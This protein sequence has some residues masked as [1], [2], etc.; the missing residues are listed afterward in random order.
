MQRGPRKMFD[1]RHLG[2]TCADCG[3]P[4]EELPF[5][6]KTDRPVY[7]PKCARDHRRQNPRVLR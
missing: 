6:P 7:C 5:M 3:A 1:V 2:L 4:I